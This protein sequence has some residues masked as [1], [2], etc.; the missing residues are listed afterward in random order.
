MLHYNLT[1]MDKTIALFNKGVHNTLPSEKIP[2]EASKDSL[3][4]ITRDGKTVLVGGRAAV[5]AEGVVGEVTGLH[6]GYKV[7]GTKVF[8]RKIGTV[9]QYL[10]G[11]TWTNIITGLGSDD[12]YVFA[13]YSSLAGAFTFVNGP[14]AFYKIINS[15]PAS[16]V[17][18]YSSTKNF[19]GKILIDKGRMLLWDRTKDKTGLYGSWIDRQDATVYTSVTNEAIGSSGSTN[20]TGTLA[21]KAGAATRSC[22]NVSIDATVAAGT[23]TFVD[24]YLGTLTSNFGGTGTINYATGAYNITFSDT[25]TGAVTSDYQ[26][27]DATVKG[28]ADFTKSATRLAGEGFVF[29]QDEGGDAILNVLI[30]QDGAYYSLK[31]QSTY[32]LSI[33]A[34]DLGATNEVYRKDMGLPFFRAAVSTN[35]GI[36]FMNTANPTKP[37]MTILRRGTVSQVIEPYILFPQFKFSDYNYDDCAMA[38]YDRW[39]MVFCRTSGAVTNDRILMCNVQD[40]TVDIVG[41]SGRMAVQDGDDLYIGDSVTQTVYL[42]FDGFDDMGLPIQAYWDSKDNLFGTSNL[43]KHRKQRI[44]GF[45]DPGQETK[46]YINVDESG[47][48]WVGTIR[49]DGSYVNYD[50]IQT[51]GSSMV[52]EVEIGGGSVSNVYG[53]YIELKL[54]TSKYR[55][56]GIRLEPVGIGYFDF[57]LVTYYDILLFEDRIPKAYR[58]K[59]DVSLDGTQTDQ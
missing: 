29:P 56:M 49:G 47:F 34:D 24:S 42:T 5:G 57:D 4:F 26:W 53:Y 18:V 50:E 1:S 32:S 16:P 3:N 31:E 9:I 25:T 21:F 54:R 48:E 8:Y 13:N 59:Q 10:N 58:S 55:T 15:H 51:I 19:Y 22:F 17:S 35:Q 33:D 12:E 43:K 52:G 40:K 39:V 7:N 44:K 38:T 2:D 27:E 23:E 46:V 28:V 37:E 11:S 45:I 41:Y 30:G 36:V 20:Y 6:A 14:T